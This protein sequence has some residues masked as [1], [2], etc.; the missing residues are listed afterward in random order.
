MN[1]IPKVFGKT[2]IR[3]LLTQNPSGG[4]AP[5]SFSKPIFKIEEEDL[6]TLEGA[7]AKELAMQAR[8]A[9]TWNIATMNYQRNGIVR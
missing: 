6:A 9:M 1:A 8:K 2:Y 4:C 7:N 5:I 3:F